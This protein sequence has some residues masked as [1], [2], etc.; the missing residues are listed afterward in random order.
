ML[1]D[2][3]L[4]LAVASDRYYGKYRGE[5]TSTD[6][7]LK[8]GRLKA[9]VPEVLGDV[10]TG[11]AL[12]CTPYAGATSG[13]YAIPPKGT[14]IWMEFEAGNPSR[15]IWAGCW[16][17]PLE[18]PGAPTSPLP[19]P[20]RREL[21]SESGLTVAL[22]DDGHTLQVSDGTGQN[23]LEIQATSGQVQLKALTQV[24]LE[25]PVIGHG[26]NA[27]E[28]AVL[29]SQLLSYL[30]QLVTMLNAHVHAGQTAGG[31]PVSPA[32]PVPALSPPTPALLSVKNLVE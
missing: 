19:S 6:D 7:P 11:W 16:W 20:A 12:P 10:E 28:P 15:P 25:A 30:S 31:V 5:V 23:L 8:S 2:T 4:S 9:K 1:E 24:T 22:D 17:G 14:P 32:P 26:Q 29:G 18:A 21:R 13:L 27:A 3:A